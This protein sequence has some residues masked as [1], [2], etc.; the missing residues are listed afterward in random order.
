MLQESAGKQAASE[1]LMNVEGGHPPK[2][3]GLEFPDRAIA[4]KLLRNPGVDA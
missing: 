4:V 1:R 3:P 2:N